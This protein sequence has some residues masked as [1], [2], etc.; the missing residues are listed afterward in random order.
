VHIRN[1]KDA[2]HKFPKALLWSVLI[3]TVTMV[4]GSLTIAF[5][6]PTHQI[7]LVDGVMQTFRYFFY[8]YHLE[9]MIPVIAVALL[10]GSIGGMMNWIISPAKG[11]MQAAEQGYLPKFFQ[12]QN[13]NQVPSHLLIT[14][15]ILVSVIC[16]VF[17]LMPSVNGSY[18]L[19]TDLST[20][21]Y[22][23]MYILMF[24]AAYFIYYK[25]AHL[26]KKFTIPGGQIG[27]WVTCLLGMT[28]SLVTLVVGFF[29]PSNINVGGALHYEVLFIV[30]MV[31]LLLPVALFYRYKHY[32]KFF[33]SCKKK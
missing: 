16:L 32:G 21:L 6:L 7:H 30:G 1:I 29:P 22:M 5:V 25:Y 27:C 23:L 31:L 9:W 24:A 4:F 26:P 19:L 28:G 10:M 14:Q 18:W 17:L 8:T 15:A 2:Q 20:Q 13:N 12:T 11:L 3:I 33:I